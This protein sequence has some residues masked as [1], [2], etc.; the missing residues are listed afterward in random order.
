MAELGLFEGYGI[1]LEYMLVERES[2]TV[3]PICDRVLAAAA[4]EPA[5]SFEAGPIAWS[6][7]LALHVIEV[8]T[9]GPVARITA[10]LADAFVG[11]L[12]RIDAIAAELDARVLPT[13]MH[14]T[15]DPATQTKLWPHEG[16]PIYAAYDR[17]FGCGGH[18]W[19]NLQ[20]CH[21]NL[22]FDGAEQFGRLH[23]AIRPL[24]PLLPALAASSP[25]VEGRVTGQ[26][27]AR[28]AVY[29][30]NQRRVA[31]IIGD[32]VPEPVFTPAAYQAEILEP[33]YRDV[34]PL[35]PDDELQYE[36]LNS[37]GAIARFDRDAIEIRL[38]DVQETPLADLAIASLVTAA[39]QALAGERWVGLGELQRLETAPLRQLL[40]RAIVDAEEAM[41]DHVPLLRA[42][43]CPDDRVS[44]REVWMAIAER[45]PITDTRLRQAADTILEH[46]PLA[47]RILRAT[48]TSPSRS[49]I[50]D[51]YR[52]LADCLVQARAFGV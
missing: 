33:M 14:P 49:C 6:N 22:P 11:D 27:D 7:E 30:T 42:L 34:R 17:A 12:R 2:L 38:L 16:R 48:G 43:G 29:A 39:A 18:G 13:A 20:S 46:G 9:N 24:L 36:W 41:I 31:S 10:E 51:V 15:M 19:G 5:S 25:I 40:D 4:G 47:R 32:V 50:H 52:E 44:A 23:A 35:D 3:A 8:K 37:R 26:L 45:L 28:L 1:E 21:I